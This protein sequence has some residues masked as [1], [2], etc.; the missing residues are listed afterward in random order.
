M[1]RN[2]IM[3]AIYCILNK[4]ASF[5]Y[6]GKQRGD[7]SDINEAYL[8]RALPNSVNSM[9]FYRQQEVNHDMNG[10]L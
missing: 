3:D 6:A 9:D 7:E 10:V 8:I 4:M 1:N 2:P 5:F